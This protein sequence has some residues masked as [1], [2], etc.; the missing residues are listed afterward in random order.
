MVR[1]ELV[2]TPVGHNS[3]HDP[4]RDGLVRS[5]FDHSDQV[6]LGVVVR[7]SSDQM[8]KS[9]D[10]PAGTAAFITACNARCHR[11]RNSSAGLPRARHSCVAC[12]PDGF[13]VVGIEVDEGS[14]VAGDPAA[15]IRVAVRPPGAPGPRHPPL[16]AAGPLGMPPKTFA[17][18]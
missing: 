11:P 18:G 4:P 9:S 17:G 2:R 8:T 10:H 13:T 6:A 3:R 5:A 1:S 14:C 12:S 7:T 15:A 16:L